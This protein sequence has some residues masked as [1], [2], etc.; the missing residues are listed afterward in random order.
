VEAMIWKRHCENT[1]NPFKKLVFAREYSRIKNFEKKV[2]NGFSLTIAVS[3]NDHEFFSNVYGGSN[4]GYV[5]TGVDTDFF[6]PGK[7]PEK[8]DSV[9][10]L[11]AMD[12][13]PNIDAVHYFTREIYP[14]IKREI[15]G[16]RFYIVGRNPDDS[17]RKLGQDD[18]SIVVTGTVPD[19]RPFI[20][21]SSCTVVPIRIG[22]GTRLKIYE[23]MSMG[24]PV[25]S[26]SIGAEGLNYVD[27]ENILIEDDGREYAQCV[28]KLLRES[29]YRARIGSNAREYVRAN[30]SWDAVTNNFMKLLTQAKGL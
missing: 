15:P 26:T 13:M 17:I 16:I 23:L 14:F 20:T 12:W 24:K 19:T 30:C 5:T 22:G 4:V 2:I 7:E 21:A 29:E 27:G 10:F 3:R 18:S 28:I 9:L 6:S 11:G 1:R 25:V 8:P